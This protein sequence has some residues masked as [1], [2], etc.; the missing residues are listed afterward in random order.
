MTFPSLIYFNLLLLLHLVGFFAALSKLLCL[1]LSPATPLVFLIFGER[2]HGCW[3]GSFLRLD[4]LF[5]GSLRQTFLLQQLH[6]P[7]LL[8]H[9]SYWI[10]GSIEIFSCRFIFISWAS[11]IILFDHPSRNSNR[12]W[13]EFVPLSPLVPVVVQNLHSVTCLPIF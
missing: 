10:I 9:D 12:T 8:R 4:S 13:L 2:R 1:I 6:Q 11:D 3:R 7:I 5:S